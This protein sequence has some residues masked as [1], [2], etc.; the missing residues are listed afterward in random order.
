[1]KRRY[2]SADFKFRLELQR[3]MAGGFKS[4]GD[5]HRSHGTK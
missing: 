3:Q 5:K 4:I 1:M 2:K